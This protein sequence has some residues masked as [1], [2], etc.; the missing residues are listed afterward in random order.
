MKI[1]AKLAE[2]SA[3]PSQVSMDVG[4]NY[5][6][7][8]TNMTGEDAGTKGFYFWLTRE[9]LEYVRTRQDKLTLAHWREPARMSRDGLG[10]TIVAR[11]L[12]E[13]L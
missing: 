4:A 11:V 6:E 8:L 3:P 13:L 10:G 9:H 7:S 12:A 2:N 5:R 1:G